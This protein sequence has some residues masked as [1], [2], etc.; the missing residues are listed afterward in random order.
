MKKF[1][2]RFAVIVIAGLLLLSAFGCGDDEQN[3]P[4]ETQSSDVA[5]SESE[6]SEDTSDTSNENTDNGDTQPDGVGEIFD[7]NDR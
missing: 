1:L 4:Y 7:W 2:L 6:S 3:E 5:E